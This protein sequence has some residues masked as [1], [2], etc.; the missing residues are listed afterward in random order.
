[1]EQQDFESLVKAAMQCADL[2]KTLAYFKD[3]ENEI[4]AETAQS[5]TGQFSVAEVDGKQKIYHVFSEINEQG[6]EEEFAEFIMNVND[7]IM[8]FIA[9]FF[10][11]QFEIK[12]RD[13]YAAAGKTYQQPKRQP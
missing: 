9:W 3:C 10:Y 2:P 8:L 7:D 11:T 12:N 1:M 5:L 4:V 6:E 13:T